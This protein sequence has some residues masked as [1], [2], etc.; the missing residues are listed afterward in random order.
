MKN[1]HKPVKK[2]VFPVAGL[3]TRLLPATKVMPKE[4]L[5]IV[6]RP[7]IQLAVEEAREAGIEEF[8]FVTSDGKEALMQHFQDAP[9][10]MEN[11]QSRKKL[12]QI[13]KINKVD[14]PA[15]ALK[16]VK[17]DQPLGLGHAVW[18]AKDLVG[19]EPFA[20][21]LADDTVLGE[22]SC[23]KQMMTA[24]TKTGGNVIASCEV[25]MEDTS[26]YG[27]FKL[28]DRDGNIFS[29]SGLVEKPDPSVAPS[30]MTIF[31]RYILQPEIFA[32]LD[33]HETGAGGEIQLTDAMAKLINDQPFYG[34]VFEGER[35]D[36]GS[37]LGFVK[38]QIAFA[39][40]K[41]H[42]APEIISYMSAKLKESIL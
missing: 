34:Y 39:L 23:L 6:D 38:A 26:K 12:D 31:G 37:E 30:N 22:E 11:L 15:S 33:K 10:L 8:I 1:L 5:T 25:P 27:V 21:I 4:M 29:V 24:Y 3:G 40:K 42:L 35:L 13:A 16:S 7:L 41:P 19:D 20:V 28:A 32:Y 9:A 17:Q 2:A 18:C 36:C 14:L